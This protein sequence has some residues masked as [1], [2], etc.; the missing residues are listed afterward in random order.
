MVAGLRI[1]AGFELVVVRHGQTGWNADGRFQG[2]SDIP[3]DATGH[4][5]ALALGAYLSNV[6]FAFAV[7]SDLSRATET[8]QAILAGR[9]LELGRD[10][11][12]RE[13]QFGAWEGLTWKEIVARN[14]ELAERSANA[15]RFYTPQGGESFEGVCERVAD[16]VTSLAA[17]AHE[18]SRILVV[19]HAGPL[20]A[21]LRVLLGESEAAALGVRFVPASVTRFALSPHRAR[22]VDLNRAVT[23]SVA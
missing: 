9:D 10:P 6:A 22:I 17:R 23:D 5:Q 4:S 8:A 7:S 18:G 1:A 14:P 16:A 11:R 19:T 3:L 20:H 12:W 2:Q 13:M 21:L 15:P